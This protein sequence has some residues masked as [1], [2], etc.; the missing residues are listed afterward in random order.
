MS[1]IDFDV[2]QAFF[3]SI[4]YLLV[5]IHGIIYRKSAMPPICIMLNF[6]WETYAIIKDITNSYF[7]WIHMLWFVLDIVLILT[8]LILCKKVY[9]NKLFLIPVY[10]VT[11]ATVF[12]VSENVKL[13]MLI[14]CF[15]IDV[16]M[17]IEWLLY[18]ILFVKDFNILLIFICITKLWGDGFAFCNTKALQLL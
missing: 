10:L 5:I 3:W 7:S 9:F 2:L 8:Y 18:V 16:L 15:V 17:A 14:C 13:G 6:A 11:L 12:L 4:T 1:N